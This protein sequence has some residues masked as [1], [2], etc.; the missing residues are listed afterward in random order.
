MQQKKKVSHNTIQY[1]VALGT[2]IAL[3]F[4]F[5]A[6]VAVS[7]YKFMELILTIGV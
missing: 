7:A 6:L 4:L 3:L 2:S 1:K 5:V